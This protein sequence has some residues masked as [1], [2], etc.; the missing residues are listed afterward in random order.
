M[1]RRAACG[2]CAAWLS[3]GAASAAL[4]ASVA[5]PGPALREHDVFT[6]VLTLSNT[7]AFPVTNLA[8]ELHGS[9]PGGIEVLSA[10][11]IAASQALP[12]GTAAPFVWSLRAN[13]AGSQVITVQATGFSKGVALSAEA[14]QVEVIA[15]KAGKIAAYPNPVTGDTLTLVLN[16]AADAE[17]VTAEIYNASFH[18]VAEE[19][20]RDVPQLDGRVTVHRVGRW[21]PGVYAIRVRARY[22]GGDVRAFP[23][24][25]VR[26][27]R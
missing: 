14:V 6:L 25:K 12:P 4:T 16:L 22:P 23:L 15:P 5:R 21:A 13:R 2:A 24:A 1:W 11:V 3:A 18:L 10:P 19:A 20:W 26:V 9:V 27:E 17:A 8:A 7:G